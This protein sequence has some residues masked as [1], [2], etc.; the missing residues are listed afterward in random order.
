MRKIIKSK[1]TVIFSA[2][3]ILGILLFVVFRIFLEELSFKWELNKSYRYAFT[4]K[5]SV[6]I[7]FAGSAMDS[8]LTNLTDCSLIAVL[9]PVK[10]N[11]EDF[12][13]LLS[14]EKSGNCVV[15]F[16]D[17]DVIGNKERLESMLLNRKSFVEIH[18]SGKV[19]EIRFRK[20]ED[21]VF[22]SMVKVLLSEIQMDLKQNR[23]SWESEEKNHIGTA[24]SDY[25]IKSG[26]IETADITKKRVKYTEFLAFPNAKNLKQELNSDYDIEFMRKGIVESVAGKE[27]LKVK[28]TSGETLLDSVS[29]F[30]FKLLEERES[31]EKEEDFSGYETSLLGTVEISEKM[32]KELLENRAA[33]MTRSEMLDTLKQYAETGVIYEKGQFWWRVS[34]FLKLN[35]DMC[36]ELIPIFN[37]T[38]INYK[39]RMLLLGIL[40]SVGHGEAQKVMMEILSSEIAKN[41]KM[42]ILYIQNL[43]QVANPDPETVAFV[44]NLYTNSKTEIRTKP[45]AALIFGATADN[46]KKSGKES[47]AA[48]INQ[49]ILKDLASASTA[50]DKETLLDA[51][52]NAGFASNIGMIQKYA[53]SKESNVRAA[54]A[55]ALRKT[56]TPESETTLTNLT[57]D[58]DVTVQRQSLN[59]LAQYELSADTLVKVRD[60][61]KGGYLTDSTYLDVI[62]L[63]SKYPTE[64]ELIRETLNEMKKRP[65]N[66]PHLEARINSMLEKVSSPN[67]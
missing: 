56:Q 16:S 25:K 19:K 63:F 12:W 3:I 7:S 4:Y 20:N 1:K 11:G 37:T 41:D 23:G 59:A 15:K 27:S 65:L 18:R 32:K 29:E 34:G 61:V 14:F 38:K 51:L 39:T 44:K 13:I 49:A 52:S 46:L 6:S 9:N 66:N 2:S 48:T 50:K 62:Q 33:N 5:S 47:D 60:Q 21:P 28:E 8:P 10:K 40:S 45:A 54:V 30:S 35:P 17:E 42:Y 31:R 24:K 67:N 43:S 22:K 64:K 36:K 57:K 58:K 53:D 26:F 55:N